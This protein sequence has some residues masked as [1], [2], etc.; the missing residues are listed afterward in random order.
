MVKYLTLLLPRP[1]NTLEK[2]EKKVS[3]TW[4][5]TMFFNF[6]FIISNMFLMDDET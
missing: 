2:K 3:F 4:G 6:F 5:K 1:P